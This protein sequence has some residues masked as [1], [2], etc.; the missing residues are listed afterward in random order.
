MANEV[1]SYTERTILKVVEVL[2][3]ES[4]LAFSLKQA[5]AVIEKIQDAGILFREPA[6]KSLRAAKAVADLQAAEEV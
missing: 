6:E 4:G 5:L 3:E 1:T 2:T